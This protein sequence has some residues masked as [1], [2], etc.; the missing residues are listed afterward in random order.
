LCGPV[1]V[2]VAIVVCVG[3]QEKEMAD[4]KNKE[5]RENYD[6]PIL[7]PLLKLG[8]KQRDLKQHKNLRR[9][10]ILVLFFRVPK[11]PN[12]ATTDIQQL[13]STDISNNDDKNSSSKDDDHEWHI[14]FTQR[15]LH[16][17]AH[18]GEVCFPGGKQD[19]VDN[20]DDVLT[21]LRETKEEIG[22][23]ADQIQVI[24]QMETVESVGGLC[25]TPIVAIWTPVTPPQQQFA[26][27]MMDV[28]KDE[29]EAVFHVPL[30]YFWNEDNCRDKREIDWRGAKFI[31]RTYYWKDQ[32]KEKTTYKIW[33]LTAHVMYEIAQLCKKPVATS[34]SMDSVSC[35]NNPNTTT[36]ASS[37]A[38]TSVSNSIK[39]GPLYRY[40]DD[41]GRK[42]YWALRFFVLSPN[43]ILHQYDSE[44][45]ANAKADTATKKN[46]LQLV[47]EDCQVTAVDDDANNKNDNDGKH[48]FTISVLEGRITWTFAAKSREERDQ[49]ISVLS[50]SS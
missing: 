31:M 49:W 2:A 22:L 11:Q 37:N 1:T 38:S 25:V 8:M 27:N 13:E 42:P 47:D 44:R 43:R 46:R 21:A 15:P 20:G 6:D 7:R 29:V 41:N 14:L 48:N 33:G 35:S 45:K 39:A 10:S 17:K 34:S 40:V 18:P 3:I 23:A 50:S 32:Y 5:I 16:L 28:N 12:N 9:A 36:N 26:D 19:A 4:N 30:S 24:T